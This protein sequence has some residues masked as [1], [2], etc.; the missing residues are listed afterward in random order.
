MGMNFDYD[1]NLIKIYKN[2][3][4][5]IQHTKSQ[6]FIIQVQKEFWGF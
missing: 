4:L 2:M 3:K 1:S 5:P 6:Y